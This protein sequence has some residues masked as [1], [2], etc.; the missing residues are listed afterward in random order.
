MN[1]LDYLPDTSYDDLP[2]KV[3]QQISQ[4]EYQELQR[5]SRSVMIPPSNGLPSKIAKAYQQKIQSTAVVEAATI[6]AATKTKNNRNRRLYW[7]AAAGWLLLAAVTTVLLLRQPKTEIVYELV[8]APIPK[9][10]MMRDTIHKI[11]TK[12]QTRYIDNRDTV[13]IVQSLP[14]ELVYLRDTIYLPNPVIAEPQLV[15][16]KAAAKERRLLDLLVETD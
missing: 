8:S 2:K 1:Y 6:A 11:I 16:S 9:P 12:Y 5:V 4:L 13:Y 10:I 15:K 14:A 3:Q 7:V